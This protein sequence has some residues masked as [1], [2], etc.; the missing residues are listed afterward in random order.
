[1]ADAVRIE[2][3][4]PRCGTMNHW[5]ASAADRSDPSPTPARRRASH[6]EERDGATEKPV[7]V[8]GR[9]EPPR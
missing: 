6:H 3:K 8:A 7:G 1:M 9:Q 2:I 5:R 4:C